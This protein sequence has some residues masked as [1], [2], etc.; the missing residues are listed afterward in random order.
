MASPRLGEHTLKHQSVD[1]HQTGLEQVKRVHGDLLIFEPIAGDLAALTKKDEAI[2]A[3]PG[4]DD[5]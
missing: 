3:V 2:R 5:V 1:V 4:L